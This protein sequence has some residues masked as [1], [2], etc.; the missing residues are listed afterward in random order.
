MKRKQN[1][2]ILVSIDHDKNKIAA[3]V[4]T[5]SEALSTL[6]RTHGC[7]CVSGAQAQTA[8]EEDDANAHDR[9]WS[10]ARHHSARAGKQD[11]EEHSHKQ[12]DGQ[13]K[14]LQNSHV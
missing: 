3:A 6:C 5:C 14:G 9:V 11:S 10:I 13:D 8:D 7:D 4:A 1:C 12:A 2:S